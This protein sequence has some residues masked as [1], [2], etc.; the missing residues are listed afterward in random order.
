MV[1]LP[2]VMCR[3]C[4]FFCPSKGGGDG[5]KPLPGSLQGWRSPGEE[6][7]EKD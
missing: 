5:E 1:V 3:H 7:T 6:A 2:G 4:P